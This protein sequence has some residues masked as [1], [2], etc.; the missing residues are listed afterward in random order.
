MLVGFWLDDCRGHGQDVASWSTKLARIEMAC[1]TNSL[2]GKAAL[3]WLIARMRQAGL[4]RF[5]GR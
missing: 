1:E 2:R 5:D 3:E 4:D